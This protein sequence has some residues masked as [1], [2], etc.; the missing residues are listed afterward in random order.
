MG[1]RPGNMPISVPATQPANTNSRL[2]GAMSVENPL[3]MPSHMALAPEQPGREVEPQH[4]RHQQPEHGGKHEWQHRQHRD[5]ALAQ[6][7]EAGGEEYRRRQQEAE[8]LEQ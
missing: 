8:W 6:H 7:Q 5:S 1:P 3:A 2:M 4:S